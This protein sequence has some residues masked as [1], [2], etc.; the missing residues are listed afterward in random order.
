MN[1]NND[2]FIRDAEC[3]S[4][5]GISRTTRWRWEAEGKFPK[6]RKLGPTITAWVHSEIK[7][8]MADQTC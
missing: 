5:T 2:R 1:F 7:Q 3:K 6:R 8:W 4:I